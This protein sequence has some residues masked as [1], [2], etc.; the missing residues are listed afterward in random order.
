MTGHTKLIKRKVLAIWDASEYEN[1]EYECKRHKN[2]HSHVEKI[3][4]RR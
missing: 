3:E 1:K 4:Q 2:S